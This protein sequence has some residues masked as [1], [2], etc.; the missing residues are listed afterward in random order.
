MRK[1][2]TLLTLLLTLVY[3]QVL[4]Q[5]RVVSG[6]VTSKDDGT[7]LP[8]V[9][10]LVKGTTKGTQTDVEGAYKLT[11]SAD[12]K[13]LVFSFIGMTSQEVTIG[14][15]STI[16]VALLSDAATLSEVVVTAVGIERNTKKLGYSVEQIG[17]DKMI[18]KSEP[19]VLRA[20]QGKVAGVQISSSGGAAGGATRINIRGNNTIAGN[21][22][23]L[24]VIDGVPFNN[25]FN[26]GG[27]DS[28]DIGGAASNR[29]VDIDPNNI[30]SMTI[31]KGAAAGALYG[32]RAANGVVVITTKTGAKRKSKRG[33]EVTYGLS[34]AVEQIASMPQFTSKFGAGTAQ[35]YAH[36]NGN[37]GPEFGLGRTYNAAGG[38]IKNTT[39]VDSIPNWGGYEFYAQS[40]PGEAFRRYGLVP[41]GNVAYRNYP[42]N[43]SDFFRNGEVLENSIS[44]SGGTEKT[45]LTAV[46][47]RMTNS[48]YMPG[49]TF[50][51]TNISVGGNSILDNGLT[52]G[53]SMAYTN[54]NQESP[55]F[56]SNGGS[57]M[58]RMFQMPRNWPLGNLPYEDPDKGQTFMF[59]S[60]TD[61]PYWSVRNSKQSSN[62]ER[63]AGNL[64]LGYNVFNWLNLS[65]KIGVNAYADKRLRRISAGSLTEAQTVGQIDEDNLYFQ[66]IESNLLAT[67]SNKLSDKIDIK[68]IIGHNINQRTGD[69]RQAT[70]LTVV[71]PGVESLRNINT[72]TPNTPFFNRRRLWA[73]F[74][75]VT[76]NYSDF[77]TINGTV[78][79][80]NSSTLPTSNNSYFYYSGSANFSVTDAFKSLRSDFFNSLRLRASYGLVGRDANPY[81]I[82]TAYGINP[83]GF[84]ASPGT[85]IDFPF[86]NPANGQIISSINVPSVRPDANLKPEFTTEI[87]TGLNVELWKSRISFDVSYYDRLTTGMIGNQ[88]TSE[89]GGYRLYN[90][91]L[92]DVRNSGIEASL[93]VTPLQLSNSLRWN[94]LTV[95][96]K[97]VSKVES[98]N[99]S[100]EIDVRPLFTNATSVLR[101]GEPYGAIRG[102]AFM[103]DEQGRLLI[104]P[105]TG[106]TMISA[107]QKII[108]DPN[109][110][111]VLG[112][113]NTFSFKGFTLSALLDYKHGG[114]VYSRTL[115]F[116]MGRG[117]IAENDVRNIPR[118]IPGVLGDRTTEKPL[119]GGDGKPVT[120][121]IQINENNVWFNGGFAINSPSE[122]IVF[123]G[124]VVRLRELSLGYSVPKNLLDK[125][126]MGKYIGAVS[127]TLTGRNLWYYAPNV[128]KTSNFDPEVSSLGA[129]N[130]QGF[131]FFGLP[132]VR[133][134]GFNLRV[135]F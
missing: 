49:S 126:F 23:P 48:S 113:T 21:N 41:G 79:N 101:P 77:L 25:D 59:F 87:E 66:E 18:Q 81:N 39:G 86:T 33:T 67:F 131:D 135:T 2:L 15:Q 12:D 100:K 98:L 68:T 60:V 46:I 9:T 129:S 105:A 36:A 50:E 1:L 6:K 3:G 63:V 118:V 93:S 62:V 56:G 73:V 83:K 82:Y 52:V 72:L 54:S 27:A 58:A 74:A 53:G 95:F 132:S 128:P 123:D 37:W 17:G 127:L 108:G 109:P 44:V 22:Q 30:E 89:A 107:T 116:L 85:D 64:N 34:Y 19:D 40:Y 96:T 11:L 51:R 5:D 114:D 84:L 130:A 92:G 124:S 20:M 111:F 47:S 45:V 29:A 26:E 125:T 71:V 13:I 88:T 38:W 102:T 43:V 76:M 115:E 120:N 70:G 133:R 8:G 121:Q 106:F 104:D 32:S 16:N 57:P 134:Y 75:D 103:R 42:N 65:Y 28:R 31:L 10:V 90:T 112:V 4:A 110:K 97:N 7:P 80:D 99:G 14:N 35:A 69:D 24:F 91:N 122:G 55:L 117:T 119:V 94:I 61:N 78:R